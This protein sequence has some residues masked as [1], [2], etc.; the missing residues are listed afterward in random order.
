MFANSAHY[1]DL[2]YRGFKD[3]E[4]EARLVEDIIRARCPRCMTVLDIAC[5]T[6]EHDKFLKQSFTIEGIDL[7]PE[8]VEI[9]R[10]KNPECAY[11]RG[12]MTDFDL[13][14][15]FD[16]VMCL[17]SSIGYVKTVENLHRAVACFRRHLA[18][19]GVVLVEPWFT[20]RTWR[21]GTI[22][23]QT[24]EGEDLKICRMNVSQTKGTMSSFTF[25]YLV[26][27]R[28]AVKY[29]QEYHELGLFSLEE[30]KES[31]EL[32]GL[33][34]EYDEQGISGRGL[35]FGRSASAQQADSL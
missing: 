2:I 34:V 27:T 23:M 13:G 9:A 21:P 1:Y 31:F 17:F 29:L 5:G 26:G 28:D 10:L 15:K 30:M 35:Y 25:H 6:G 32:A 4:R 33:S 14:K 18:D 3:Y 22:H 12:D 7:S 20:P 24:A 8:F 11:S 19:G 16:V